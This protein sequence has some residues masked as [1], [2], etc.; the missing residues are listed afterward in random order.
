MLDGYPHE[1]SGGMVQR[2]VIAL[3]LILGA[4]LLLAD[5]P[6]TS[7]DVTVQRQ[8]LN[9]I[10]DLVLS[11][12]SSMLLVTHDLGVVAQH[13]ETVL[14]MYAGKIV[15]TGPVKVVFGQPAHPYTVGL[16][17]S[18][19]I[20]RSSLPGFREPHQGRST[21]RKAVPFD[22]AAHSL[23]IAAKRRPPLCG[24]LRHFAR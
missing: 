6:T 15:E 4:D 18:V 22:F 14:V 2:V 10:R 12:G 20:P 13:C 21:I 24:R 11:D 16:L 8:I 9:L 1:L 7:L 17:Q 5:E 19:L 23:L 3:A